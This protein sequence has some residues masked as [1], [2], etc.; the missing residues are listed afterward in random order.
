MINPKTRLVCQFYGVACESLMNGLEMNGG[1]SKPSNIEERL[2]PKETPP[3]KPSSEEVAKLA[4]FYFENAGFAHGHD[5]EHWFRAE[6]D[7]MA[8]QQPR[9]RFHGSH[10]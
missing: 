6:H 3:V 8:F 1:T 9:T 7:L 10:N 2:S 4:Y 5:W